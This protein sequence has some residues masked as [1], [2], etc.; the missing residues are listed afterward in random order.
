MADDLA[1]LS[2]DEAMI[3]ASEA[4]P[5][6]R[7]EYRDPIA[8]FGALAVTAIAPW[9]ADR[10]YA[11]FAVRTIAKAAEFGGRDEAILALRFALRSPISAIV[12]ADIRDALARLGASARAPS[13]ARAK[14]PRPSRTPT[15]GDDPS[16]VLIAGQ[17]YRRTD[18]HGRFGGNVQSGISYPAKGDFALLFSDPSAAHSHGYRDR[19]QD[20]TYRY[21]GAW[22]GQGDMVLTAHNRVVQE[23]SPNL[24]LLQKAGDQ[25]RFIGRFE[26]TNV[27]PERTVRDGR[28]FKAI[29]FVLRQLGPV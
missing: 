9:L 28:E 21:Y 4:P 10:D 14:R 19:W 23:R 26:C 20:G 7:I 12:D 16:K 3:G 29:V 18:L 1:G 2:L 13:T 15:A 6:V 8:R 25:W 24:Y 27:E 5:S 22:S 17:T 11:T